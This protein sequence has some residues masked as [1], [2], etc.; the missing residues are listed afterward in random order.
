MSVQYLKTSKPAAERADDDAKVR[1]VVETTLADIATRGDAAVRA[2][3]DK[4]DGYS[5]NSFRLTGSEIEAAMQKVSTRDMDDIT[6][7]QTQ[8]R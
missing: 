1:K 7:A 2:L 6:F 3:S 4:F 8:I 5:P